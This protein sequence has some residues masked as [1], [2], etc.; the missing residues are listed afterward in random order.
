MSLSLDEEDYLPMVN[1]KGTAGI[2]LD[3]RY[4]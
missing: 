2:E 4:V 3:E 1:T